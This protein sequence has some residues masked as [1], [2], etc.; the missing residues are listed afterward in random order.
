MNVDFK[1]FGA[2]CSFVILLH[3]LAQQASQH[4]R[5]PLRDGNR[6]GLVSGV[7]AG[8]PIGP[9]DYRQVPE[10]C[11]PLDAPGF[12]A[13]KCGCCSAAGISPTQ[14][15]AAAMASNQRREE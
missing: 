7:A 15:E 11:I 2:V 1:P 8:T 10:F 13:P 14:Q 4:L 12:Y 5:E 3:Q 9:A 6:V